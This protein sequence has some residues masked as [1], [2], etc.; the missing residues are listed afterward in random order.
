[1]PHNREAADRV[2]QAFTTQRLAAVVRA[3]G[4]GKSFISA[5][6][7]AGFSRVLLPAPNNYAAFAAEVQALPGYQYRKCRTAE[8]LP[9]E[10]ENTVRNKGR[11]PSEARGDDRGLVRFAQ[12]HSQEP[13]VRRLREL[14]P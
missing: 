3:T 2:R 11:W 4:T 6:V 10:L 1:M 9:A 8:E 13:A 5:A 7:A 14:L 12:A